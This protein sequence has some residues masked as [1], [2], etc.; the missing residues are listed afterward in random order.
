MQRVY[1][2]HPLR[3]GW[4]Q[5]P[6]THLISNRDDI[7]STL[8]NSRNT[9]NSSP[10]TGYTIKLNIIGIILNKTP[11][12]TKIFSGKPQYPTSP[13]FQLGGPLLHRTYAQK[14]NG[15]TSRLGRVG[16]R[17][18]ITKQCI[19]HDLI[20]INLMY[21]LFYYFSGGQ[22]SINISTESSPLFIESGDINCKAGLSK[23]LKS[24]SFRSL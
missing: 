14:N 15:T 7:S 5:F 20:L 21:D 10:R 19:H 1:T 3:C 22:K 2:E 24:N 9:I 12:R 6:G 8:I 18:N 23:T 4:V 11:P 16:L 13:T 17:H